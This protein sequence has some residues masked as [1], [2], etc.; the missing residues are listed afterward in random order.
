MSLLNLKDTLNGLARAGELQRYGHVLRKGNGD[1]L[2][3]TLNF[4]VVGRRWH[5]QPNMM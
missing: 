4:E 2:R 3:R 1:V 5:W